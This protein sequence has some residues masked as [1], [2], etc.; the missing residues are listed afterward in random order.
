M[1]AELYIRWQVRPKP[2]PINRWRPATPP[3]AE[4]RFPVVTTFEVRATPDTELLLTLSATVALREGKPAILDMRF[5]S[6]RGL[7]LAVLQST[8]K[9]ETSLRVVTNY[10]L[11]ADDGSDDC[12]N[13]WQTLAGV[14]PFVAATDLD[15]DFLEK[16]AHE[17]LAAGRGYSAVL[18]SRYGISKRSAVRWVEKAR[19]RGILTKPSKTGAVGG[20]VV[21]R[22]ERA[23]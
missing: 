4:V 8:F 14:Q 17:Y 22:S 18:S 10:L 3:G 5:E 2:G 13:T 7:D 6:E 9:W 11:S 16:I 21:P 12:Y 1:S 20:E 19:A 15:D 23:N